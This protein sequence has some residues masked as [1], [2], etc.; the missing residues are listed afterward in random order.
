M[1]ILK[2]KIFKILVCVILMVL[3]IV[4]IKK[5]ILPFWAS[6]MSC[7]FAG[8]GFYLSISKKNNVS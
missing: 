2:N 8:Y 1:S 6:L 5:D 3:G 4:L 7:I